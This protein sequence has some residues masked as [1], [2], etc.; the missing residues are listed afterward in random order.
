MTQ[1]ALQ[2]SGIQR[3]QQSAA[4]HDDI[5]QENA[6]AES[7]SQTNFLPSPAP[8]DHH[9]K[10]PSQAQLPFQR[11][12]TRSPAQP[13]TRQFSGQPSP[14]PVS[15]PF[16]PQWPATFNVAECTLRISEFAS[17][18]DLNDA[19]TER[20]EILY[21]AIIQ[22]DWYFVMLLMLHS[23]YSLNL[24][25]IQP[26]LPFLPQHALPVFSRL[27]G[28]EW[29]DSP[30]P[31]HD[32]VVF[33][34][35]FPKPL[36][37]LIQSLTEQSF[38]VAI[39]KIAECLDR[40]I[41]NLD[42]VIA[43]CR[44]AQTLPTVHDLIESLGIRS[45][46]FQRAAFRFLLRKNWGSETGSAVELAMH[47][48][49]IEQQT[50]GLQG[51]QS[52]EVCSRQQNVYR[53]IYHQHL[54]STHPTRSTMNTPNTPVPST[55]VAPS[56]MVI[57]STTAVP[58]TTIVAAQLRGGA[59]DHHHN[60]HHHHI[61]AHQPQSPLLGQAQPPGRFIHNQMQMQAQAQALAQ[62]RARQPSFPTHFQQ[63]PSVAPIQSPY[64]QLPGGSFPG[65]TVQ[66]QRFTGPP[67]SHAA[68]QHHAMMMYQR[69]QQQLQQQQQ[70]HRHQHNVPSNSPTNPS[71]TTSL[72]R[73]QQAHAA[74]KKPSPRLFYPGDNPC[75]AQPALPD[76]HRSA[77]HQA[78]LR[79]PILTPKMPN[80]SA[81]K[82]QSDNF[83]SVI[84]FLL[85][86][87]R[88]TTDLVQEM[89][90]R[91]PPQVI[92][93]LMKLN[94]STGGAPMTGEF[95]QASITLRLRCCQVSPTEPLPAENKWALLDGYWPDQAYFS[96]NQT[97]LEP[98]R[99]LHH[100]KCPPIELTHCV[101][102]ETNKLVVKVNRALRDKSPFNYAVA[103]EVV[104][105]ASRENIK[106]A[107]MKR[108]VPS[109][110][111]L[112]SIKK[113]LTSDDDDIIMQSNLTVRLFEPF[114]NSRIFDIPVRSQ[115][116]LHREAFDLDV[117]LDTRPKPE[118]PNNHISK[119]DV[120]KCP[121]CMADSR[122][123][124][125][126]VDGF[127]L[128][129]RHQLASSNA[130]KTR[131]ITVERDGSWVAEEV[132]GDDGDDEDTDDELTSAAPKKK[133][134]V[135]VILLDDD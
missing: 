93:R 71:L 82:V 73:P 38:M 125:L 95:D 103:I 68:A 90:F 61:G 15:Q 132:D 119:V 91:L 77:L 14:I 57:P 127:L 12:A 78:H 43:R 34:S 92:A 76:Y 6:T 128:G 80:G 67:I 81:P 59:P 1:H 18:H 25:S 116:C 40:I 47:E 120:W 20:L 35:S 72:H 69:R 110:K 8:S 126:I 39:R 74:A 9:T 10:S 114:S 124:S 58:N 85:R 7:S 118:A 27:L 109:E 98:R 56:T 121:I 131:S 54:Y 51:G 21:E 106:V 135:E 117:F 104:G 49:M 42:L 55:T 53:N 63:Q 50:F 134:H 30:A 11:A 2:S 70:H 4:T 13:V 26:L 41:F 62:A 83:R 102:S 107:C 112:D 17:S 32:L 16:G 29:E 64:F 5:T 133:Q 130:L 89:P 19:D 65:Y 37:D 23:C 96:L 108:L 44:Q 79:S 46:L 87:H 45:L 24:P 101:H 86:P 52:P 60:Q 88:L 115:D 22:S 99:K 31:S 28:E 105:F 33:L 94:P 123:Q 84:G 122:P 111:I 66:P 36:P 48:F 113:S 129:V 100:G 97:T 75:V 3:V